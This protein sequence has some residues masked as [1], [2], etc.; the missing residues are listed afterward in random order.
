[1]AVI[2]RETNSWKWPVFSFTYM[3]SLAYVGA[4]ITYQ[5]GTWLR[6]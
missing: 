4:M 1:L 5:L 6:L 3:T 2:R